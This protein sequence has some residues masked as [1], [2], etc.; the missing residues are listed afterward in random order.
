MKV[1]LLILISVGFMFTIIDAVASTN[2]KARKIIAYTFSII[3]LIIAI[4][5]AGGKL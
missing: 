4:A 1:F 3:M 5:I 2:D